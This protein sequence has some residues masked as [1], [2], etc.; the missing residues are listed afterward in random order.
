MRNVNGP[1]HK[2]ESAS[3]IIK[4]K[5]NDMTEKLR[6]QVLFY[7]TTPERAGVQVDREKMVIDVRDGIIVR[8]IYE[9]YKIHHYRTKCGVSF[10][11]PAH[12]VESITLPDG[13][14]LV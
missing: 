13:T 14:P 2:E 3:F 5:G 12:L 6:D 1:H 11:P 7:L 9:P 4:F 8:S 10:Y